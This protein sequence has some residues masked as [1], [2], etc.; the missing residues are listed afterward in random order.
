MDHLEGKEMKFLAMIFAPYLFFKQPDRT[1]FKLREIGHDEYMAL[2]GAPP[3]QFYGKPITK[4]EAIKAIE[5]RHINK[6]KGRDV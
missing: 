3:D 4:D 1:T 2:V 5:E 6:Q